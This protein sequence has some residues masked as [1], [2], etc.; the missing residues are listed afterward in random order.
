MLIKFVGNEPLVIEL[1]NGQALHIDKSG[2]EV[3]CGL[4]ENVNGGD[5]IDF[6]SVDVSPKMP[7]GVYVFNSEQTTLKEA[8]KRLFNNDSSDYGKGF[9]CIFEYTNENLKTAKDVASC[10]PDLLV[11]AYVDGVEV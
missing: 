10:T 1:E 3:T 9:M 2:F 5:C 4:T 6:F 8:K 7:N 11:V